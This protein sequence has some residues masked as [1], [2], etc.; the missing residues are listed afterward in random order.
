[1]LIRM[2]TSILRRTKHGVELLLLWEKG[3]VSHELRELTFPQNIRF[4]QF[5]FICSLKF[6]DLLHFLS[7]PSK[8][9]VYLHSSF[10]GQI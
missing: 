9:S 4:S 7:F 8:I 6:T 10:I 3:K 1:M 5:V 2:H